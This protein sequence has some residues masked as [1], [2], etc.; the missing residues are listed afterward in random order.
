M[1]IVAA[2][3]LQS[4]P[5]SVSIYPFGRYE[6]VIQE[7]TPFAMSEIFGLVRRQSGR[8][9]Y[10]LM[11]G[12][13]KNLLEL[14]ILGPGNRPI[15]LASTKSTSPRRA[16]AAMTQFL[17]ERSNREGETLTLRLRPAASTRQVNF[18]VNLRQLERMLE[19]ER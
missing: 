10:P 14:N 19:G 5:A 16:S 3:G 6:M 2:S 9:E 1:A 8:P 18:S 7:G 15:P 13:Q 12:A 17:I 4:W 11:L